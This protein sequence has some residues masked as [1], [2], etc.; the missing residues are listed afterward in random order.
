LERCRGVEEAPAVDL[1]C[2]RKRLENNVA[3]G[4]D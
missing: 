4:T 3:Y 2:S 1:S